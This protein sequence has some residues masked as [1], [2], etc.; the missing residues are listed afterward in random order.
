MDLTKTRKLT[1]T[2]LT[3]IGLFLGLLSPS[4]LANA[5][6]ISVVKMDRF[7]ANIRVDHAKELL[8]KYYKTSIVRKTAHSDVSVDDFVRRTVKKSLRGKWKHKA[9]KVANIILEESHRQQFDPTFVMAVIQNESSFNTDAT[10]TSGE[11]GL[12][13]IMPATG[14]WLADKFNYKWTSKHDLQDPIYNIRLGTKFLAYLRNEF[15]SHSQLYL[16]A[17]NMGSGNVRKALRS[18]IWPKDYP[19]AVM[20]R[21]VRYHRNLYDYSKQSI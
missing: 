6:N 10:G 15:D 14:E 3:N 19:I 20:K 12:M 21:Y 4:F 17:Y 1:V 16:A 7:P 13:Q 8:G 2:S 18:K 9:D 5:S 11:V